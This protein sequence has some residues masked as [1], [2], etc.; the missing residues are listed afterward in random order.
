MTAPAP[1][2]APVDND[3]R[4]FHW[5]CLC[6]VD[7]AVCGK[8]VSGEPWGAQGRLPTCPLCALMETEP[9]PRCG[10]YPDQL[11]DV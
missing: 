7:I 11:G 10:C 9:C 3:P 2:V 1:I 4:V 8:D 5:V 6:D